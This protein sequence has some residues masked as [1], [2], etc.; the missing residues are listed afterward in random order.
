MFP[1]S[2]HATCYWNWSQASDESGIEWWKIVEINH[3]LPKICDSTCK[4]VR[5][6]TSYAI[7]LYEAMDR[8]KEQM[9]ENFQ[10]Q[11]RYRKTVENLTLGGIYNYISLTMQ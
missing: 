7:Y 2:P 1:T 4:V 8:D 10:K 6:L 11:E 5:L 9:S 3:I